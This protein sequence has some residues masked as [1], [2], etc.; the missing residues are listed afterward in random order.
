MLARV[1]RQGIGLNPTCLWKNTSRRTF[2]ESSTS[3]LSIICGFSEVQV[4]PGLVEG[5]ICLSSVFLWL[6]SWV[7][8]SVGLCP[9]QWL[10]PA[11]QMPL[12]AGNIPQLTGAPARAFQ[13]EICRSGVHPVGRV[14]MS[15]RISKSRLPSPLQIITQNKALPPDGNIFHSVPHLWLLHPYLE[16]FCFNSRTLMWSS[17]VIWSMSSPGGLHPGILTQDGQP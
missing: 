15:H 11:H 7:L 2:P 4:T 17:P 8:T 6:L 14:L 9:L 13:P 16:G 10:Q 5:K 12:P 1:W 3:V